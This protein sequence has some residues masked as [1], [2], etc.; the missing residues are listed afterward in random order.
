MSRSKC[1]SSGGVADTAW[2]YQVITRETK[3]KIIESAMR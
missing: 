1:K 3:M 2:K